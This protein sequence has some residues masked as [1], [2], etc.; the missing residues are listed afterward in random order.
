MQNPDSNRRLYSFVVSTVTAADIPKLSS[1][2]EESSSTEK[3]S[4]TIS[5]KEISTNSSQADGIGKFCRLGEDN[6]WYFIK[7][8]LW[9]NT[10]LYDDKAADVTLP[11]G[12][13]SFVCM[14]GCKEDGYNCFS[15]LYT[16][17]YPAYELMTESQK[18]QVCK[19]KGVVPGLGGAYQIFYD[20]PCFAHTMVFPTNML[21][22]LESKAQ[23]VV[24]S[25]SS[26][27]YEKAYTAAWETKGHERSVKLINNSWTQGTATYTVPEEKI[28]SGYSYVTVFYF[29]DGTSAMSEVKHKK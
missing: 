16:Y 12:K 22:E 21:G 19:S 23:E 5:Y 6:E 14:G 1:F 27:S 10:K 24:A 17:V 11:E 8:N 15:S 4:F 18:S 28:D 26:V 29:A 7:A 13:N 9:T 25:D 2:S 3:Y 20:A